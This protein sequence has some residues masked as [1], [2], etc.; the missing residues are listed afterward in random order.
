MEAIRLGKGKQAV[1]ST[2]AVGKV[3]PLFAL[4][5]Q[6]ML[7]QYCGVICLLQVMNTSFSSEV[8]T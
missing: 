1:G 4:R 7:L 6:A 8:Q 5:F 3:S 2:V